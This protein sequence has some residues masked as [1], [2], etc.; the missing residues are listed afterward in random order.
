MWQAPPD[1][2]VVHE[3]TH[4]AVELVLCATKVD[5]AWLVELA[6]HFYTREDAANARGGVAQTTMGDAAGAGKAPQL[7]VRSG[8]VKHGREADEAADQER[9]LRGEAPRGQQREGAGSA[10]AEGGGVAA[11]LGESLFK[12]RRFF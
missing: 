9:E 11:L 8:G 5:E 7:A 2:I 12:G 3:S 10:E 1:W 6:P 4:A